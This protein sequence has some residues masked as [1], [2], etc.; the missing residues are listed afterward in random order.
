MEVLVGTYKPTVKT[1]ESMTVAFIQVT[2]HFSQIPAAFGKLYIWI[3][4]NGYK[5]VGPSIAVYYN[6]PGQ[7]PDNELQWELRSKL[8]DD[9]NEREP[10]KEGLGV[11]YLEAK[12]VASVLHKGPYEKVEDTYKSLSLWIENKK[13]IV[14]GPPEE[15]Y[16][17]NPEK[18]PPEELL[19]E[20]RFPIQR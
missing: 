5:P 4:E 2:G 17:N 3:S 19:T 6:I 18:V 7:V 16:Y 12:Y 10:N 15:L 8:S 14:N 11:K 9:V 20:I 13:I 1:I